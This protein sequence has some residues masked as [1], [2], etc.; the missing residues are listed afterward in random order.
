ML[1]RMVNV[2]DMCMEFWRN[3]AYAGPLAVS[4]NFKTAVTFHLA[5]I[6]R[7]L[8]MCMVCERSRLL[9]A[10]VTEM[11]L[12]RAGVLLCQSIKL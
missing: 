9:R 6:Q 11:C 7:A 2:L 12:C 3:P 10:V 5:G 4:I 8:N 1:P